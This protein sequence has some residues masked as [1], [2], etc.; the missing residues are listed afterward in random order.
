MCTLLHFSGQKLSQK[1]YN[2]LSSSSINF[3]FNLN[4][5]PTMGDLGT[6][7]QIY[8]EVELCESWACITICACPITSK[9]QT[10]T[11]LWQ[12]VQDDNAKIGWVIFPK[13]QSFQSR[14][15]YFSNLKNVLKDLHNVLSLNILSIF[16]SFSH[17]M[18]ST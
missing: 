11:R 2:S 13:I 1:I 12:K 6:T 14:Q 3:L 4:C 5:A 10:I 9:Y 15:S 16:F 18:Y 7:W 8:E 17:S